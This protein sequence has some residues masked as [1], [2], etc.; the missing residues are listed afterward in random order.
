MK[1]E[2]QSEFERLDSRRSNKLQR[3]QD[4]ARLTVPG[5]YPEDGFTETMDLPDVFSSLPARGV[6]ALAS[7]MVSAIYPLN[8][9]PFFNFEL[10]QAFVPQGTDPTETMAQL[11]RLDRKIMDKLSS[12]NLRQELFV[13][14][15]HLIV[16]GDALFEIVD[17]YAFRVHRV[18]QYVVQRY[19]DG[20]VKRI[21]LREWVDPDAVPEDWPKDV[22]LEEEYEGI[23]PTADH[24]PFYTEIEWDEATEKWNVE[25]EYCGVSVDSGS[26]EVCPYVPQVWSRVAGEDYGRSLVEEHIGDIR[27][28]ETITK[29]L[30]EAAVANSE[31]RIGVDPTGITEAADLQDTEN[32]DF[33]PARQVDVFPIQLL[34]QIDLGP[35][36]TLRSDLTQQLG[37]TFLL[38]SSVQR[39]GDRVT[40]TEIREVAQELDQTLGGIF[41]GLARDIQIP[42]VKRVLVLMG[43]EKLVPKEIIKLIEGSGPLNLKV[44]TGLE[45]LNREV[46]NSQLSQ[47]AAVVGQ[48]QAVQPFIDWYGWAIKWTSSFGLEPV[49]LV[50]TPQQLQEEQ[51]QQAQQSIQAMASE[52]MVSSLGSM[53]EMGTQA[54]LQGN[55][56][57]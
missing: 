15:Q 22:S 9:A 24:K 20:R 23:G 52:Q 51:Q 1:G 3:A 19:P 36:A 13:L 12:T 39:T 34:K 6:M 21:V 56:T 30:V 42:I 53:A 57:Q 47:W 31:F 28:L 37:R 49:G 4:C 8:Q 17:D 2:I 46:T 7:R 54:A 25:K 5:L 10:D 55:K 32:G 40:A 26:F 16:C 11:G 38:Q 44:R 33:V 48:T 27:T 14:F 35:M 18:D 29:A 43:R 50:K 41:S 45:A